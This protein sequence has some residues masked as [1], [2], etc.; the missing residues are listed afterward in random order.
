M[1]IKRILAALMALALAAGLLVLPSGAASS[2]SAFVDIQDPQV[3]EAA[4]LLRLL[5]VVEGT[6]G[7]SFRPNNTL[8]RAEFCKMVVDVMGKGDLEP[9]QRG[10]TIFLDVGPKH[11]ARGYVNLA[12]S[13]TTSGELAQTSPSQ[14]GEEKPTAAADRIIMGVGNGNFEPDRPISYG[15]AVAILTRIL[16]YTTGDIAPGAVWYDG[17]LAVGATTGL[18]EGINR[19]GGSSLT[20]AEAARLFE[21]LLFAKGKGG[22]TCYLVSKLGGTLTDDVVLLALKNNAGTGSSTVTVAS[23]GG[24]NSPKTERMDLSSE[25]LGV[26]GQMVQDKS[27]KFLTLRPNEGD[28]IRRITI[29]G[30]VDANYVTANGEQ[31]T[32]APDTVVWKDGESTTFEKVWSY[33][34]NGTPL[35]LCYGP[36][37]KLDYVYLSAASQASDEV[38][39]A[40]TKPDGTHNPFITLVDRG[41]YKLYKNGVPATVADLRQYDVATYDAGSG[42]LSVSDLRL[43]G[44]YENATPNS[45]APTTVTMLGQEFTVL[46]GAIEDLKGFRPGQQ[47]TLLFTG[48]GRVAGALD[49]DVARSTTVGVVE[50]CSDGTAKVKPLLRFWNSKGEEVVFQGKTGLGPTESAKLVGQLVTVSSNKDRMY[51]S[52][53]SSGSSVSGTL[54][55][56]QRT[57]NGVPLAENVRMFERVG[58]SEPKEITFEQL[59]R[60]TVPGTKIVYAGRDYAGKYSILV[61]DDVTGDQY[62]YGYS[63]FTAAEAVDPGSMSYSNAHLSVENGGGTLRVVCGG[64]FQNRAVMGIAPSVETLDGEHK[65][66]GYVTLQQ[67]NG[68]VRGGYDPETHTLQ[69][70]EERFPISQEVW[71]YNR[72]TGYWFEGKTGYERFEQARAYSEQMRVYYDKSPS[73]GGKIRMVVVD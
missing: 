24:T 3:A 27:G 5:G 58:T 48:D 72:S 4:E 46:P 12:S 71:C 18:T 38:L 67:A 59:T 45:S 6:G 55:V 41:D 68:V 11:W 33:L 56:A 15:E 39:V 7:G 42:I 8:T 36:S 53:L 63:T 44:Y 37:G 19:T 9:A 16:G 26:R 1:K 47:M 66:A 13:L 35:T 22:D 65:L 52:R 54:N 69:V 28:T 49:P 21:N 30:K 34:Y 57:L 29:N 50:E 32:I 60:D 73:E 2:G 25:L 64:T 20:R 17:Y 23:A 40:R 14:D 61:F 43:T 70:G 62:T 31:I 51:L 10:R